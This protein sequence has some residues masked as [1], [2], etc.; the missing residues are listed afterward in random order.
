MKP[1]E[2]FPELADFELELEGNNGSWSTFRETE[3]ERA[4]C[5]LND[6]DAVYYMLSGGETVVERDGIRTR[7]RLTP[8]AWLTQ[9]RGT[10]K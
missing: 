9:R 5:V 3:D 7:C 1:Q 6:A 10:A 4:E 2:R 8:K